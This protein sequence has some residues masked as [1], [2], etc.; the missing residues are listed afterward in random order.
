LPDVRERL[1]RERQAFAN[2]RRALK[3]ALPGH[4]ADRNAPVELADAG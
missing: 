4:R 3:R 2:Q 1:D